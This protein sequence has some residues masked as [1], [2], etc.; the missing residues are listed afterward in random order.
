MSARLRFFVQIRPHAIKARRS[1]MEA[2]SEIGAQPKTSARSMVLF[3]VPTTFLGAFL[4]F[5]VQPMVG[6]MV[7]PLLGGAASVWITC[8]MFFQLM[9]LIGY[10]YVH[11]LERDV[12][13]RNQ[14]LIHT[15]LMAAALLFVPI[16]FL[17][18]P[19]ASA[20]A[21]PTLWLLAMLARSVGLPFLIVSTTAPI[22]QNWL[23]KTQAPAARDP[24]FLYAISNAGS[25]LGLLAYPILIEPKWG[26]Q[27]QSSSWATA[28]GLFMGLVVTTAI[29]VW[30]NL[31]ASAWS[32]SKPVSAVSWS[33]RLF[34]L[35]AAFVPS[36]LMLAVTNHML[37]NLASVPFLWVVPLAIYLIT[38]MIAFARRLAIPQ[39]VLS[40]IVPVVLL[41]LFPLV[42]VSSPVARRSLWYVLTAHL[43]LLFAGALLCHMALAARRPDASALTEFYL[44]IA[45]GGALG[46]VFV[47][48]VAPFAFSTVIEYPLLVALIAFFR[49]TREAGSKLKWGD[50]IHPAAIALLMVGIRYLLKWANVEILQDLKTTLAFDAVLVLAAYIAQKRRIRFALSLAVLIAGYR[51]T[52]PGIVEGYEVI[53]VNRDFFGIKKVVYDRDNTRKLM[54]GDTLHGMESMDPRASGYPLSYYHAAGPVGDVMRLIG[55]RR[56]QHVAVIGLGA[57]TMAAWAGPDR[58][59]TFFDIDP[60]VYKVAYNFFTYLRRCG[61]PCRVIIGDGRLSMD[62]VEDGSFDVL[63][64]DAFNS[65][66]IPTHLVS[67]EAI[68]VYLKKLKPDGLLLFHVSNRYMNVEGIVSAVALDAGLKG[69][70][71]YDGADPHTGKYGSNY[72]VVARRIEDFGELAHNKSWMEIKKPENIQ[73]W[74]DDYSNMMAII[75]WR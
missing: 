38:F 50:L 52:L 16:R 15:T 32:D 44:W 60:L 28:Y 73:P 35:A 21:Y 34:W 39:R 58:R 17:A 2:T 7:L 71:R 67:R 42:T 57:G 19:D 53:Q 45:V 41:V 46:G 68:Q 75:R 8:L 33:T 22:L 61:N 49:T 64:L 14:I 69:M 48:I 6:K 43:V 72:V 56:D 37:L 13:V 36:G 40:L 54:H 20:S 70:V 47:A 62:K 11:A 27:F 51:I 55:A 31:P 9:L 66:S 12:T 30:Q 18:R 4:L 10:A 74:T 26:V 23:S 65:D 59:M 24:Y 25:L 1:V 5:V 63:M 3:L 29:L